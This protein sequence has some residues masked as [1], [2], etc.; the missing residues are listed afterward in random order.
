MSALIKKL[1]TRRKYPLKLADDVTVHIR[2]LLG[3]EKAE[4]MAFF[5][6]D[7]SF[8]FVLGCGLLEDDGSPA[9]TRN[10]G[11]N[12][13]DFGQRVTESLGEI[14]TDTR[15]QICEAILRLSTGPTEDQL[16]A[17]RKN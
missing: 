8:G 12:G 9:F 14:P 16:K 13:K 3:A 4:V 5:Q 17:I 7:E 10:E 1:S 11:E 15:A 2:A 6:E